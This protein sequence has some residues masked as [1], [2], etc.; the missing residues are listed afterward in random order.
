MKRLH[1]VIYTQISGRLKNRGRKLWVLAV[2]I[3]I[4][5]SVVLAEKAWYPLE[6]DVWNPPFNEERQRDQKVYT[7]LD[8]AQEKWRIRV[9]IPHLK[10]AYWLGVNYG[11]ID[12]ARRLGIGLAIYEAGGYDQLAV[13]RRQIEDSLKENPNGVIIGAIS[14]DGLNDLVKKAAAR[15]IP[16][17]DL[18]NGLA[19]PDIAAR[20]AVSFWDMGHQAGTYL[21]R[22]QTSIG[23]PMK[24]AWFP[25]PKGAGWVAAGDAGFRK[26][27]AGG[28]IDV[29]ESLYGD[30]G[31]AAQTRLIE[32]VLKRHAAE[33][34]GIVGTAVTA[35]AAVKILRR[36]G[37]ADRIKILSY[38]YSPGVDRGIRR[39]GITAAPSD[40]TVLQARIAVDVMVRILEKKTYFKHVA[41]KVTVIDRKNIRT[42]DSST[43]LAPRGFRPIFSINE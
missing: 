27:I 33:L 22:L 8:R 17:L 34:D 9:F 36:S 16:V 2:F 25:G 4:A 29:V 15:G 42:W 18:I 23:K 38:Y 13:Q 31:S 5:P 37:L 39:G 19:S 21:H 28:A 35:E 7:P 12:E 11:L 40:L 30:T 24:V 6:V 10:D 14:L 32:T 26:A 20:A 43:T 41:P 3:A 1:D